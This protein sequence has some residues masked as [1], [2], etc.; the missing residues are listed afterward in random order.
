[1]SSGKINSK[2]ARALTSRIEP[3][4]IDGAPLFSSGQREIWDFG[5]LKIYRL[6]LLGFLKA[7]IE[8]ETVDWLNRPQHNG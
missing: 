4:A 2:S 1:M 8:R 6:P 7:Q 3:G 5:K